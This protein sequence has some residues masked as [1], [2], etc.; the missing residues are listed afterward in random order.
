MERLTGIQRL[1]FQRILNSKVHRVRLDTA[2]KVVRFLS[3]RD[4]PRALNPSSLVPVARSHQ[5]VL[6]LLAQGW[7]VPAQRDILTRERGIPAGFIGG[8]ANR[9][10]NR[11]LIRWENAQQLVWLADYVG[12]AVGPSKRTRNYWTKHG[13]FP[14]RHYDGTGQLMPATL[15]PEQRA[16]YEGV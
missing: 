7:P 8:L 5:I 11:T 3:E 10:P 4:G 15:S 16:K 1:T 9:V 6:S 12:D 2:R 13:H 14:L